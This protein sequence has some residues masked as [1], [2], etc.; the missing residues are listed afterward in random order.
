MKKIFDGKPQENENVKPIS[1][2]N[3]RLIFV[4]KPKE[5]FVSLRTP[6]FNIEQLKPLE[7]DR[8]RGLIFN[9]VREQEFELANF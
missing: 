2:E 8:L 1:Y 9:T 5:K 6:T 3:F 4:T 7:S